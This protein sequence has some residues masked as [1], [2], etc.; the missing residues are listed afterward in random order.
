MEIPS[1]L[2][3]KAGARISLREIQKGKAGPELSKSVLDRHKKSSEGGRGRNEERRDA[4]RFESNATADLNVLICPVRLVKEDRDTPGPQYIEPCW[5]PARLSKSGVLNVPERTLPWISRNLLEPL[6]ENQLVAIGDLEDVEVF[7][8]SNKNHSFK[9]WG[10][11][12][13]FAEKFFKK[14]TGL[15]LEKFR[16]K[17]YA[18]DESGLLI[19]DS[20]SS[21]ARTSLIKVYEE[22]LAGRRPLGVLAELAKIKE[23]KYKNYSYSLNNVQRSA[24]KHCGQFEGSFPLSYSQRLA[25]QRFFETKSG[26]VQCVTGPPGTGKTTFLQSIIASLWV[27]SALAGGKPPVILACSETNRAVINIINSFAKASG[28]SHILE[29][30]WL[31]QVSSYGTFCCSETKSS[32]MKDFQLE[33]RSGE[34]FSKELLQSE[35]TRTA[36]KSF[37][38]N[39]TKYSGANKRLKAAVK[40]LQAELKKEYAALYREVSET[41]SGSLFQWIKSLLGFAPARPFPETLEAL[42]K[43]DT[44]RRYKCFLLATHY[45]EGRWLLEARNKLGHKRGEQGARRFDGEKGD[46]QHRAMLTPA[47][48]ST[49]AMA[50]RFFS[51]Y[52]KDKQPIL[53]LLIY[54]EAGQISPE[55]GAACC[56]LASKAL[57]VGDPLQLEPTWEITKS[58]DISNLRKNKIAKNGTEEEYQ[59]LK[60]RGLLA[61]ANS[62]M[63][64]ALRSS[65]HLEENSLGVFL[66]EHRRSVPEIVSFAN[67]IAY[68]GRLKPMR[69]GLQTRVLP[70][71]AYAHV[72][73]R[74]EQE[75]STSRMN[76]LEAESIV[77]WLEQ[78][79][80]MICES[81][82]GKKLSDLVGVITPFTGQARLLAR[83]LPRNFSGM[84]VGTVNSLQG[85]ERPIIIFSSA[86]DRFFN[87]TYY[88]DKSP[89]FLN[90]AV[91]RAKD[92]FIVFG[93]MEIFDQKKSAPSSLLAKYLFQHAE[94]E[95]TDIAPAPRIESDSEELD[96]LVTLEDHQQALS[97]AFLNAKERLL[98][99]S[100]TISI[101][102]IESDQIVQQIK[103]TVSRGVKVLIYTDAD[104]NLAPTSGK[105]KEAA[106]KGYAALRASG[107]EL[108]I[109]NRIHNK[110]LAIDR[111][112]LIEGSFN[113]LSAVRIRTSK[114]QKLEISAC[115]RGANVEEAI[116][117]LEEELEHRSGL[118]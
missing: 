79:E 71:F 34:G 84:L 48:V 22:L 93:D 113:W 51:S 73:G 111:H 11:Y 63:E 23:P 4:P 60:R 62:L 118:A 112:T 53:D 24:L 56:A 39:F 21:N 1:S 69:A 13:A 42:A 47:F 97:D 101:G 87:G 108:R 46:W 33:L 19:L 35:H 98:I 40:H 75:G 29:E 9:S 15:R 31:P 92:S 26:E 82:A 61:S 104:L 66:S 32:E 65:R 103:N 89:N 107:A 102:A 44:T 49:L 45:W 55:S 99:V 5:I 38:A 28:N 67:N 57:V 81:Y 3:S 41:C 114:H 80:Q 27:K 20:Q 116:R 2:V 110:S 74:S 91:S 50:P 94:N 90:V 85:A 115:Y 64:L 117:F 70:A 106:E 18:Q 58:L 16:L 10:D 7:F 12:L 30:R 52:E 95:I 17:G 6:P 54:D 43:F 14:I 59:T 109:A 8:N 78:N 36:E 77:G 105:L 100:P 96:R 83:Q 68:R 76:R 37:L 86:Y 88:F 25:V 72:A